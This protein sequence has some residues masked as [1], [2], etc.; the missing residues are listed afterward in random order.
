MPVGIESF[1]KLC[2]A[3]GLTLLAA[4]IA[5]LRRPAL[6]RLTHG[7]IAAGL[8]LL[9]LAA[10]GMSW[11]RARTGEVLVMLDVSAS[12]R[13][14]TYRDRSILQHRLDEL[15]GN[16]PRRL[17][18]FAEDNRPDRGEG[19]LADLPADRTLFAP[20]L[21]D[22][23]LLFSDGRFEIPAAAPRTFVVIDPALEQPVDAAVRDLHIRGGDLL[24]NVRLTGPARD[25]S[26][27]GT[28]ATRP[29]HID[30]GA[31]T[32][33][34]PLTSGTASAQFTPGDA[35]PENDGLW[36]TPPPAQTREKWWVGA[37]PP[38]NWRAFAPG[39]LP[40]SSAEYLAPAVIVLNNVPAS[41][42]AAAQRPLEQY[43]RDLGGALLILGGN[44]AFAAGDYGGSVL[45]AMSPL[46]SFPPRPAAQWIILVD[47]SGSMGEATA[48]G[49][50]WQVA[51]AA[52]RQLLPHLPPEDIA[53]IGSF[54]ESITWWTTGKSVRETIAIPLP[55]TAL[56]PR[57]PT[58]LQRAIVDVGQSAASPMP[59]RLIL[60]TDADARIEGAAN[61]AT[62][63]KAKNISLHLL[64]IG[65]GSALPALRQIATA[66]GGSVASVSD[67]KSWSAGLLDLSRAAMPNTVETSPLAVRFLP[68]LNLPPRDVSPWN[69]SWLKSQATPLGEAKFADETVS[70]V[71]RWRLGA[72][73][74]VAAAFAVNGQ[75]ATAFADSIAGAPRDP[76][77]RVTWES[78]RQL[79]AK[80]D[81]M[82]GKTF[83]NGENLTL[84]LRSAE[85]SF[86]T[87]TQAIEQSG[88]GQ[89]EI[90]LSAPRAAAFA[91]VSRAGQVLDRIA[92][93]GR[94]P[95]EFDAIGNDHD[96]MHELARRTGGQVIDLR[97]SK[98]IDFHWPRRDV[99]ISS[100]LAAVGALLIALGLARW[101]LA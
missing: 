57:G 69:H 82:D 91:T 48:E 99:P 84:E 59:R 100:W 47:G 54:A 9:S 77:F 1:P 53:T 86:A 32:I 5:I 81:A 41:A 96:A 22:A 27:T 58:N 66:T 88:P 83:L 19:P 3:L 39:A 56:S 78:G 40:L 26:L 35:W 15:L 46:A 72:G 75:E 2:A 95:P 24:A 73:E 51:T 64:A 43:I 60:V 44:R 33:A 36:I 12:T 52:V 17:M 63:L 18:I 74:V 4:C 94:Y 8:L 42:I 38:V 101:R 71:A 49:T 89:Y 98:P 92:V 62:D 14:A 10:G 79:R 37:S 97:Q 80:V 31:L 28:A 87:Q 16:T 85:G 13:T 30:P 34:R 45:E 25:L 93:A 55:P 6:P 23:V 7:L 76:R 20:P 61:I 11:R 21:A 67:A 50:R 65:N 68:P 90:S 70:P 29:I